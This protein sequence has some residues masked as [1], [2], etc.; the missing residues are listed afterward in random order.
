M[1]TKDLYKMLIAVSFIISPNWKQPKCL[2]TREW[3]N[4]YN[5]IL[6]TNKEEQTTKTGDNMDKSQKYYTEPKEPDTRITTVWL[7][8]TSF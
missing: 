3:T 2:S 8:Y 6:P 1:S 5:G 4:S 7:I